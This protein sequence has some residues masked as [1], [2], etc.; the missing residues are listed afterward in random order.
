[1][2]SRCRIQ[3]TGPNNGLQLR[4]YSK[5]SNRSENRPLI[6]KI[7]IF[8]SIRAHLAEKMNKLASI[9]V[10]LAFLSIEFGVFCLILRS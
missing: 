8:L 5:S 2:Q 3:T 6:Y 4:D 7:A 9:Y 10:I 1:M